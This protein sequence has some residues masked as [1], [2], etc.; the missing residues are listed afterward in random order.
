MKV[1][2]MISVFILSLFI[3][4]CKKEKGTASVPLVFSSLTSECDS[5]P[6]NKPLKVTAVATGDNL[7]YTWETSGAIIGMGAIVNFQICHVD[8]FYVKCTVTD[9]ASNTASKTI[10]VRSFQQ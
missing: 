5:V 10:T 4:S 9:N 8:T 2:V 6:I 7:S 1:K 3:I